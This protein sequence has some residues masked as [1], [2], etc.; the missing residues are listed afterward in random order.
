MPSKAEIARRSARHHLLEERAAT[1]LTEFP[2]INR[3]Y[4]LQVAT[5]YQLFG[6]DERWREV[7]AA[8]NVPA[9]Q[10]SCCNH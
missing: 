9:C 5:D 6:E 1:V 2:G 4:A 10:L 7:V 3:H 8:S